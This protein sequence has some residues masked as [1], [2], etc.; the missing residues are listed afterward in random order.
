ML[1][2]PLPP[3]DNSFSDGRIA[4]VDIGSNSIRLVVYDQQKRSP[5]SIYNEKVMC[6]LG[7]GLA[8]SGVLNPE[9]VVEAKAALARFLAMGRNMEIKSLY[10]MATA[11]VRDASDGGEF[12]RY[13]EKAYNIKIDVISG[14]KEARLGAYGVCSSMHK[15]SGIIGDLGGGS[16]EL[17]EVKDGDIKDHVSLPLGSLRLLDETKGD[18]DKIRKIIEKRFA[19]LK[20]LDDDPVPTFYAIGGSFRALAK[21]YMTANKYPLHILHEFTADAKAF[22]AFLREIMSLSNEKLEKY[23]GSAAKRVPQLAGAALLLEKILTTTQCGKITFSASG[24]REGYVYEMLPPKARAEDGL[25]SSCTEFAS[26]GGRTISY[27]GDLYT[28]MQPLLKEEDEQ[29]ARLRLAFCLLSEIALHIH[30][31]YRADW[32]FE[33]MIFSAMTCLT[34]RERVKLAL[35]LYYRYQYKSP[36]NRPEL[37]L[38]SEADKR[39]ARMVGT[40]ANL[41]YHLSGSI[42]GNLHNA[43]F[44]LTTSPLSLTLSDN[45]KNIMGDAVQRR[46]NSLDVAYRLYLKK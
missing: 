42:A 23:P 6:G 44:N 11:A 36:L 3:L 15:P 38:V 19:N 2:M 41:A 1:Q 14:E 16:L 8:S 12:V 37:K 33:R 22:L 4:I 40:S 21:M 10:I 7:K 13:L 28:W 26:R 27:A 34:H 32:A 20:W 46:L 17:V 9:G 45:M 35:A 5:V 43:E 25:I 30:P 29:T 39:W 24:I 31:E 18:R